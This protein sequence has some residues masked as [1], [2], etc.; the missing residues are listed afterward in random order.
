ME[1]KF[2]MFYR[3]YTLAEDDA[4]QYRA[5][6]RKTVAFLCVPKNYAIIIHDNCSIQ[7]ISEFN[8]L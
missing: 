5:Y 8:F 4:K 3:L 7:F 2:N 1:Y 6:S